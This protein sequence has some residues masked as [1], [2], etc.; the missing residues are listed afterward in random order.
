LLM[1]EF[2]GGRDQEDRGSKSAQTN[3]S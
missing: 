3:S 2:L 1:P